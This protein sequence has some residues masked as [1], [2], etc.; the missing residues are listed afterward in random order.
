METSPHVV[1]KK[2]Y[3]SNK[4]AVLN[5]IIVKTVMKKQILNDFKGFLRYLNK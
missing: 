1:I 5:V 3:I 2:K 4:N